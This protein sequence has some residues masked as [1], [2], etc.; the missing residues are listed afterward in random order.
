MVD[1]NRISQRL[2]TE[3]FASIARD[4]AEDTANIVI[5]DHAEDRMFERSI[6]FDLVLR[7]LR[8][9]QIS[10]EG[11]DEHGNPILRSTIPVTS[12]AMSAV[13]SLAVQAG[14]LVLITTMWED[15]R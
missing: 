11:H 15:L 9:G 1:E 6:S 4:L 2:L 7:S 3:R 14:R 10:Y 8:R 5:T 13:C 12:R